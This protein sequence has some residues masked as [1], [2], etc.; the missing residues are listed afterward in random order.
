MITFVT[1]R[2]TDGQT[3]EPGYIGPVCG[4]KKEREKE[5]EKDKER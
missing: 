1:D 3:D 5:R 4:S 2:R